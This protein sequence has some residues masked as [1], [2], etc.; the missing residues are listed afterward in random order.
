[1]AENTALTEAKKEII[2]VVNARITEMEKKGALHFP[3]NYSPQNA[4]QAAWLIIQ[5]TTDK[6]KRP[7]LQVCTK[8][9]ITNAMLKTVTQGL[10]PAKK[11][12][13]YIARE[14]QLYADPSYFGN[15]LLAKRHG[16]TGLPFAEVV[17]EGDSLEYSID[18]ER[19]EKIVTKHDQKMSNI[20]D[21]KIVAA[22]A[23]AKLSDGTRRGD[24]MTIAEMRKSWGRGQMKGK[25]MLHTD[26]TA[27]ACRRTVINR[28]CKMIVN[29]SDDDDLILDG[30][31]DDQYAE[32]VHAEIEENQ[33]TEVIELTDDDKVD[34][35]TGEIIEHDAQT[36]NSEPEQQTIPDQPGF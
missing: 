27:E 1:M 34:T 17:Y 35:E 16:L 14:N 23:I 29:A 28:L 33:A 31:I 25:G 13:Y 9:S 6:N 15:V 7:V 11:Q 24:I 8:A 32:E 21:T 18:P 3:E 12:I 10:N 20:D 30:I 19:M 26:H 2:D 5:D 22:Y 36:E 4:L